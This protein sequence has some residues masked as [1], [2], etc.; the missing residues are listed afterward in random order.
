ML[1][2]PLQRLARSVPA[3]H[4]FSRRSVVTTVNSPDDFKTAVES[5]GLVVAYYTA[6]SLKCV[7]VASYSLISLDGLN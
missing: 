5:S 7:F 2:L 6:V 3:V 1:R 4:Q